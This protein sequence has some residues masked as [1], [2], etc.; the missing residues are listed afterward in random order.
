MVSKIWRVDDDQQRTPPIGVGDQAPRF[1][2]PAST[3]VAISLDEALAHGPVVLL[4]YVF[5]FGRI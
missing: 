5:D 2:L 4:W 1:T 3:G